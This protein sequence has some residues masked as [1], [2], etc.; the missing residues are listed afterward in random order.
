MH[1]SY[2]VHTMVRWA[3]LIS[4]GLEIFSVEMSSVSRKYKYIDDDVFWKVLAATESWQ[5]CIPS[6]ISKS[7]QCCI[8]SL[9][10][11]QYDVISAPK[12]CNKCTYD[13]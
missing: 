13:L 7:W 1:Y 5:Y 3:F 11:S 6:L 8:L 4:L 12:T 9:N 2:Q 10:A